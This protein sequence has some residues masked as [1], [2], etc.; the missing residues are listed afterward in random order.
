MVDADRAA[1]HDRVF[2]RRPLPLPAAVA[3]RPGALASVDKWA[4]TAAQL[5]ELAGHRLKAHPVSSGVVRERA[6]QFVGPAGRPLISVAFTVA[7]EA[8]AGIRIDP[9]QLIKQ[10]GVALIEAL[11]AIS[12]AAAAED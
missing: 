7:L 9:A 3:D 1:E 8:A 2:G 12:D 4:R 5:A 6:E 10:H 11:T